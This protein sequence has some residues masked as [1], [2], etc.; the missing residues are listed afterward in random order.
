MYVNLRSNNTLAVVAHGSQVMFA[1]NLPFGARQVDEAVAK[2]LDVSPDDAAHIRQAIINNEQTDVGPDEVY[3]FVEPW[4]TRL[5][6]E[7]DH[8]LLYY[9]STFR[10]TNVERIIFTGIQAVDKRLCQAL[11]QRLNLAAQIG[12]PMMG[13]RGGNSIADSA[14]T[15]ATQ[16]QPGLAVAVGLSLSGQNEHN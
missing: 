1:R 4:V 12:D 2:G 5:S 13:L 11:A 16:A 6:E 3:R 7:L 9:R 8:C 10:P 14:T 15:T